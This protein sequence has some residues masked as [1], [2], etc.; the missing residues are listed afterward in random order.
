MRVAARLGE[1]SSDGRRPRARQVDGRFRP[2]LA[3]RQRQPPVG[4]PR[5]PRGQDHISDSLGLGDHDRV[6]ALDLG[7]R[8]SGPLGLRADEVRAGRLIAG[9]NHGPR[10]TGLPGGRSARLRERQVRDGALRRGH[11]GGLLGREVSGDHV[12]ELRRID[13]KLDGRLRAVANGIVERNQGCRQDGVLG[14]AGN[15]AQ[16]LAF[17][18]CERRRRRR[19]RRRSWRRWRRSRS[20]TGVRVTDGEDGSR[21]LLQERRDVGRVG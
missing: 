5:L 19:G 15:F 13:P 18:G 4:Q 7:D 17:V 11:H 21:D 9:R 14:R 6:R 10:R 8:G 1:P 12:A 3:S 20:P 2:R 16:G